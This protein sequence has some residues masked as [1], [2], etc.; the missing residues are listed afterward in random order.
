MGSPSQPV[1]VKAASYYD[2]WK[3]F[4]TVIA[5]TLGKGVIKRRPLVEAAAQHHGLDT[6]AVQLLQELRRKYGN[7]PL[8]FQFL[9]RCQIIILDP[10]DAAQV[11]DE[12]PIPFTSASRE[13]QSSLDHF[14]PGNVLI[15]DPERRKQLRPVHEHALATNQRVHPFAEHFRNVIDA[16]LE[17]LFRNAD[18]KGEM[19]LD[20]DG[21]SQA[22]FRIIRRIVLGDTARDDEQLTGILDDIR[23]RGNWGFAALPGK[24][25]LESFQTQVAQYLKK[26]EEGSLVSRLPNDSDL[27]LEGQ[28]T[29]WLFAFDPAGIVTARA[30]ALLGCQ[31]GEQEKAVEGAKATGADHSFSRAVFLDSVRLWPTTPVILREL[32]KDHTIG[33][34]AVRKGAGVIIYAPLFHR[35]DERLDFAHKMSTSTWMDKEADPPKA[36]FPFSAGPAMCP[37]HNLVPMVGSLVIDVLLSRASVALVEPKLDPK[38]LP[39]TLDHFEIKLHLSKRVARAV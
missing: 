14:E 26:R 10:K 22:W 16:E 21:F 34:Q 2:T 29:H 35:D 37:A 25:K 6:K 1:P 38:S 27:G 17:S 31:P 24:R 19:D 13:K 32:T 18:S 39:G 9:F 12:T 15:A 33:G 36:L 8:L 5:P 3:V 28:I 20:W 11:L 30:L 23:R 4:R 7:G